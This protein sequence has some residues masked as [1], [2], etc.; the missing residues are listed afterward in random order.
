MMQFFCLSI[1]VWIPGGYEATQKRF[2]SWS[3]K[4]QGLDAQDVEN[5]KA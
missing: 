5:L 2:D 1:A 3:L 4:Y